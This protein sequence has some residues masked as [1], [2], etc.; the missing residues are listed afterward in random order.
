MPERQTNRTKTLLQF[1]IPILLLCITIGVMFNV[2][3]SDN[4]EHITQTTNPVTPL[5]PT[6]DIRSKIDNITIQTQGVVKPYHKINII[7]QVAGIINKTSAN[8]KPGD[9]F[10][11]GD[12]LFQIDQRD[13]KLI[14]T[15]A[16]ADVAT[17][18]Q[19]LIREQAE[20]KLAKTDWKKYGQGKPSPLSLRLPQMREAQARLDAARAELKKAQLNLAR[21][22][23]KA[24]FDGVIKKV[25]TETGQFVS[26]NASVIEIFSDQKFEIRLPVSR[27]Q[28]EYLPVSKDGN[29]EGTVSFTDPQRQAVKKWF[30][31][32][33]R[34]EKEL[35]TGT[36]QYI[37]VAEI[38]NPNPNANSPTALLSGTFLKAE[39]TSKNITNLYKIPRSALYLNDSI[40]VV[41]QLDFVSKVNI[42]IIKKHNNYIYVTVLL[43]PSTRIITKPPEIFIE[44]MK[45]RTNSNGATDM[46]LSIKDLEK[47]DVQLGDRYLASD[48]YQGSGAPQIRGEINE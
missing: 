2:D 12:F 45:I 40:L 18:E 6:T 33:L 36:N 15:R 14:L 5:L 48:Q 1:A 37:L 8:F 3:D 24:P 35:L 31:K 17:A 29:I 27:K 4:T 10:S 25:S 30:G 20:S 23:H 13:Y 7:T 19:K 21:T 42:E 16:Q 22:T 41:D 26:T 43:S 47:K 38:L 9:R 44:G 28:L 11:K 34:L 39:I 46:L 32:I